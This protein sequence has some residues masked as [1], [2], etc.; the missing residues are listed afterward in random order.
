M[1]PQ[2]PGPDAQNEMEGV[3][4]RGNNGGASSVGIVVVAVAGPRPSRRLLRP[5]F[6]SPPGKDK[7]RDDGPDD[8]VP[9]VLVVVVV[10]V[11]APIRT[12]ILLII[13]RSVI[14]FDPSFVL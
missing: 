4:Q 2:P 5:W 3:G 12:M 7:D 8:A 6:A 14:I 9:A 11:V 10:P 13:A 1:P